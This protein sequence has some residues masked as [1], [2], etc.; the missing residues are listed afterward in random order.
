MYPLLMTIHVLLRFIQCVRILKSLTYILSFK[1]W[2][3]TCLTAKL[4]YF[5]VMGVVSLTTL[6]CLNLFTQHGIYFL[7][8]CLD[9]QQQNTVAKQKHRHILE[10][11]RSFVI[12]A[13]VPAYFW[14]DA[15]NAAVYTINRLL[16]PVLNQKSPFEVLFQRVP[17]YLFLRPFGC[18]CFPNFMASSANKLQPFSIQCVF[19]GYAAHYKGYRYLN[20]L[21]G[22]V[23]VSRHVRFIESNYPFSL[24][25]L[26]LHTCDTTL[27]L[28][29]MPFSD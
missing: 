11:I 20:P 28:I 4:N 23:Y 17:D 3:K 19:L 16:T 27:S 18:L 8:S 5:K 13:S 29:M 10:M 9:T 7:K 12:D 2:W 25:S 21:S 22:C 26:D 15:A 1:L 24:W 6:L 14:L